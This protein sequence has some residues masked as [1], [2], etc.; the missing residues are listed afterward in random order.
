MFSEAWYRQDDEAYKN[1]GTGD[2]QKFR[3]GRFDGYLN[4][5]NIT[6]AEAGKYECAVETVVGTIYATSDVIVHSPPGPPGGVT[7]VKMEAKSG[8]VS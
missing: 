5:H 8:T 2:F 4:I 6:I 3:R 7:A 1:K